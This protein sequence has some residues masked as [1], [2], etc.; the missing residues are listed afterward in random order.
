MSV[1]LEER[2]LAENSLVEGVEDPRF[3]RRPRWC[4]ARPRGA[5]PDSDRSGSPT[6]AEH[7]VGAGALLAFAVLAFWALRPTE[8]AALGGDDGPPSGTGPPGEDRS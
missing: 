7:A 5:S 3:I 6:G 1:L 8:V 4:P 2:L